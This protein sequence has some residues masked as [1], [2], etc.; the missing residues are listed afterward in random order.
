MHVMTSELD[1]CVA[2]VYASISRP[3]LCVMYIS[4]LTEYEILSLE[5]IWT[6]SR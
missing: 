1:H 5:A 2:S 4:R 3:S 6:C